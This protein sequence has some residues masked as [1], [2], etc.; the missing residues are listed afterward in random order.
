MNRLILSVLVSAFALL[1]L[2]PG[3]NLLSARADELKSAG[4]WHETQS[5]TAGAPSGGKKSQPLTV[6]EPETEDALAFTGIVVQDGQQ[7]VLRDP[8]TKVV[9]Q[10]DDALKAKRY[11]GKQVKIV[12]KLGMDTNTIHVSTIQ[13]LR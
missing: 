1:G 3:T 4:L 8:V 6:L 9:Y 12:G 13:V 5:A 2:I 11:V 7:V 10:L